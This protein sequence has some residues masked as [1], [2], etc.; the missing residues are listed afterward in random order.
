MKG[1]TMETIRGE[2]FGFGNWF[3]VRVSGW[4]WYS[5]DLRLRGG[6][7]LYGF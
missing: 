1:T 2:G 7:R 3:S 4:V 5:G 6:L